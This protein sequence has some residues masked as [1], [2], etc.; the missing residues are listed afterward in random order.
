MKLIS[1]TF[2]ER[3]DQHC[4]SYQIFKWHIDNIVWSRRM[5][6]KLREAREIVLSLK[7]NAGDIFTANC[8]TLIEDISRYEKDQF[9]LW[10]VK[11]GGAIKNNNSPVSLDQ[12]G[13]LMQLDFVT[14]KLNVKYGDMLVLLLREARLLASMGYV[15][16]NHIQN[17]VK[18]GQRFYRHGVAL[19]Q[20][21]NFYNTIDQQMLPFQ[22]PMLLQLALN[23][24]KLVTEKTGCM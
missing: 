8:N 2:N 3:L 9:D 21:A 1:A 14:G 15:V 5:T 19:K 11:I 24:E 4:E 17:L 18:T 13:R 7:I 12:T 10:V 22:Q 6:C 23:F 20:I 16:P